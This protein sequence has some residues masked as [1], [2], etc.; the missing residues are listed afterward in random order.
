[1]NDITLQER[2]L[3]KIIVSP[4]A[5]F[6]GI[7]GKNKIKSFESRIGKLNTTELILLNKELDK[8]LNT[9]N[10]NEIFTEKETGVLLISDEASNK[11]YFYSSMFSYP[12]TTVINKITEARKHLLEYIHVEQPKTE[13]SKEFKIN[14]VNES[15]DR[16]KKE[17]DFL[18]NNNKTI[19]GKNKYLCQFIEKIKNSKNSLSL[20]EFITTLLVLFTDKDNL[21]FDANKTKNI[22]AI[23][24]KSLITSSPLELLECLKIHAEKSDLPPCKWNSVDELIEK[25]VLQ[26]SSR[27]ISSKIKENRLIINNN[28]EQITEL[29]TLQLRNEEFKSIT[30][31]A[32]SCT[33]LTIIDEITNTLKN[34]DVLLS[35]SKNFQ[36]LRSSLELIIKASNNGFG[37]KYA[38]NEYFKNYNNALSS[39]G[40]FVINENPGDSLKSL[41]KY[42]NASTGLLSLT[43]QQYQETLKRLESYFME[44]S[45]NQHMIKDIDIY[46]M[47]YTLK[48]I[49]YLMELIP[50]TK[51]LFTEEVDLNQNN[52]D[53]SC[54]FSEIDLV[55]KNEASGSCNAP[56]IIEKLYDFLDLDSLKSNQEKLLPYTP[57]K[58]NQEEVNT[59]VLIEEEVDILSEEE[60]LLDEAGMIDLLV[61]SKAKNNTSFEDRRSLITLLLK[62]NPKHGTQFQFLKDEEWHILKNH[63]LVQTIYQ[64]FYFIMK[65]K[66]MIKNSD[67]NWGGLV[68]MKEGRWEELLGEIDPHAFNLLRNKA[69]QLTIEGI[70]LTK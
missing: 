3:T 16:L 17:L 63:P 56:L 13:L 54:N 42:V 8:I 19:E 35:K 25:V 50:L 5:D 43:G 47:E 66:E 21:Y 46:K 14:K 45:A 34:A 15:E 58:F 23:L 65:E 2:L 68:F 36:E 18:H 55:Q 69:L 32:G 64:N 33:E 53:L 9:K 52:A 12:I 10:A 70:T 29:N 40:N 49:P 28:N 24:E 20:K 30:F 4:M 31:D 44:S 67:F 38:E 6:K 1:M 60:E 62:G 27:L 37:N 11:K 7:D 59:N 39:L 26:V 41:S 57:I 22:I 51:G 48:F 61:P